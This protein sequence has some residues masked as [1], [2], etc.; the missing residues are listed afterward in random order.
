[1]K[2]DVQII[3]ECGRRTISYLKGYSYP[4]IYCQELNLCVYAWFRLINKQHFVNQTVYLHSANGEHLHQRI[5]EH[6]YSASGKHLKNDEGLKTI[7]DLT[8]NFFVFENRNGK[9]NF[10][11]YEMLFIKDKKPIAKNTKSD[12]IRAKL[13]VKQIFIF[14]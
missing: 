10:L 12:S 9:L 1:M 2:V 8:S 14:N 6:H 7:G 13:F 11:I 4:K 3:E 5:D